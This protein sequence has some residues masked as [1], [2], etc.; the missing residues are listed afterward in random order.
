MEKNQNFR[1]IVRVEESSSAA[2][3]QSANDLEDIVRRVTSGRVE[4]KRVR[5]SNQTQDFGAT[6]AVILGTPAAIALAKGVHQFIAKRGSRVV[7]ETEAGKVIATGDAASNIDVAA[8]IE[9]LRAIG[10]D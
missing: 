2:S 1:I 6:L 7:I 9:K 4:I 8:T 5:E 10:D 3:N